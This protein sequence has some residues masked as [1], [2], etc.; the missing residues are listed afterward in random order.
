MSPQSYSPSESGE[1]T[2]RVAGETGERGGGVD[3]RLL[4]L[5]FDLRPG[6]FED[7]GQSVR[8]V[9]RTSA[10]ALL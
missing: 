1:K 2:R 6:K 3:V 5:C 8:V 9:G 7:K 10:E 4:L